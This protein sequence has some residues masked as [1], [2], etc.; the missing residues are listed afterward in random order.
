VSDLSSKRFTHSSIGEIT[1]E[2]RARLAELSFDPQS[3]SKP[4]SLTS[5]TRAVLIDIAMLQTKAYRTFGTPPMND[6]GNRDS[7]WVSR[8]G[9][10]Q[11][12]LH[13][14]ASLKASWMGQGRVV[15][16][17]CGLG[18]DLIALA[19]RGNTIGVDNDPDVLAFTAANLQT[20]NVNAE[21]RCLDVTS[22]QLDGI[23]DRSDLLHIDPDRRSDGRRHTQSEGLVPSWSRA[24]ELLARCRGG[25]VKLAPATQL[26][27]EPAATV[28]R[29]WISAGGSVRE[30]T[31]IAG[32]VLDHAWIREHNMR[33]G[34]RS[35][36]TIR[37][38][39]ADVFSP[40][41]D[42]P[43]GGSGAAGEMGQW[44]VDPDAAIRA[45]GLTTAF[46]FEKRLRL[47]GDASGFLSSDEATDSH[48]WPAMVARVLE[49][50]GCDDRKLRR[51][52]RARNAYPEIIKVRGVD[53]DPSVLS[54]RM[55]TCGE[56][57]LGLWIGRQGKRSYAAITELGVGRSC[58]SAT[59]C[60]TG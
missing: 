41:K 40:A 10:Q 9:L 6:D 19:H 48:K 3:R 16:L 43:I 4:D 44:I 28:H 50:V 39:A 54:K 29:V 14:I 21:L 34:S 12:T 27:E 8:V 1:R 47:V 2:L 26:D 7:W 55:K 13:V 31:V 51:V 35:A 52:F 60:A 20:V 22:E 15:D 23:I 24:S 36:I 49:V 53:V 11:S 58:L 37:G 17:C 25:L 32:E 38:S 46:A 18:S 30:Q 59:V 56:T 42:T 5:A 57:P 33:A 45:A